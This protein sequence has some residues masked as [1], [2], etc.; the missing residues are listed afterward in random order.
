MLAAAFGIVWLYIN[1]YTYS[2]VYR[3]LFFRL[4]GRAKDPRVYSEETTLSDSALPTIDVLLPVYD[5][6]ETIGHN[7]RA[8]RAADYPSALLRICVLVEADDLATRAALVRLRSHYEFDELI[9]PPLYPGN[10][11]KPRALNYGFGRTDGDIVGVIDAE[12]IVAPD[13]FQQVVCALIEGD[14][15]YVQGKLDMQNENDGILNTLFR[16][17]YGFWYGTVIPAFFRVDYPV[18]LGGTT[19]FITRET[20]R[21]VAETRQKQFGSP[22]TPAQQDLLIEMD[23]SAMTP[24]DPR[25]VTE[26]F[27]L[28]LL[29]WELGYEMA[30]V[31]AT[32]RG[33][34]PVGLNA[35]IKQRTRWQKGKLFTLRERVRYPPEGMGRKLH[36]YSQAATP[37][38]GPMNIVAVVLISLYA[39]TVGLLA[40]PVVAAVLLVSMSLALQQIIIHTFGYWVSTDVRGARRLYR[41][42]V[43]ALG[44][45]LYWVLQWGCDIRAF[46][47]LIAGSHVWEKTDHFGRHL[48]DE[49]ASLSPYLHVSIDETPDG[50][51]WTLQY[52][53]RTL[54]T[55]RT[56]VETKAA[57]ERELAAVFDA[58]PAAVGVDWTF[59]LEDA[60]VGWQWQLLNVDRTS[61]IATSRGTLPDIVSTLDTVDRVRSATKEASSPPSAVDDSMDQ[62]DQPAVSRLNY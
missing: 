34:S 19:N 17:E 21:S 16:G 10:R 47:Q 4:I 59:E 33:E 25:N 57:A 36:L 42:V 43:T 28:G 61:S 13:L 18:P 53:D 54:T 58:L 12:D 55:A 39:W 31:T 49:P 62:S 14:H 15:D 20:L 8:L 29:L 37:H 44:V 5:E 38:L 40:S 60:A 46:V 26:D 41:T 22:W 48:S 32:T 56:P 1:V 51:T 52:G 7:L 27:E 24:W 11:N 30:L 3:K 9:V 50:W 2:P 6:T 45:P 35:W 23:C